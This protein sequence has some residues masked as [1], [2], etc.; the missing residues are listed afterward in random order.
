MFPLTNISFQPAVYKCSLQNEPAFTLQLLFALLHKKLSKSEWVWWCMHIYHE[1]CQQQISPSKYN[2]IQIHQMTFSLFY[3]SRS[4][5]KI[6]NSSKHTLCMLIAIFQWNTHTYIHT[7]KHYAVNIHDTCIY[8]YT[9]STVI[10][11]LFTRKP[12][13]FHYIIS[14]GITLISPLLPS[15]FLLFSKENKCAFIWYFPIS[16]SCPT[17]NN[18]IQLVTY[19]LE[20]CIMKMYYNCENWQVKNNK[21]KC[22][23]ISKWKRTDRQTYVVRNEIEFLRGTWSYIFAFTV[24]LALLDERTDDKDYCYDYCDYYCYWYDDSYGEREWRLDLWE[25]EEGDEV[26]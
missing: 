10:L 20:M 15:Y 14:T 9:P 25:E 19:T 11:Q 26:Q 12:F 23:W 1:K 7:A 4:S 16:S 24:R 21:Y 17:D 2:P 18:G 13:L 3:S 22:E 8:I 5:L 6:L